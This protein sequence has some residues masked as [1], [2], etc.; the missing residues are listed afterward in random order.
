MT[1]DYSSLLNKLK[2][3]PETKVQLY[4]VL[5]TLNYF[6]IMVKNFAMST[7]KLYKLTGAKKPMKI[8]WSQETVKEYNDLIAIIYGKPRIFLRDPN[9]KIAME[10]DASQEAIGAVLL[11]ESGDPGR[12]R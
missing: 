1:P 2:K 11:Q 5:Q 12:K 4:K 6:R 3:L 9:K 10:V 8:V 7:A